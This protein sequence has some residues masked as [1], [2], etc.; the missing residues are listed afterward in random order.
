MGERAEQ[1]LRHHRTHTADQDAETAEIGKAAERIHHDEPRLRAQRI[2]RQMGQIDI[3][4]EFIEDRFGTHQCRR[5]RDLL[6]GD[7]DQPHD[8]AKGI[9]KQALQRHRRA[10]EIGEHPEYRI[11]QADQRD[12]HHQHRDD[13]GEKDDAVARTLGDRVHRADRRVLN[14]QLCRG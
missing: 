8:R 14:D 11:D 3:G 10:R 13:I 1:P 7:P 2:R 5:G 6:G 9:G 12:R 4:D